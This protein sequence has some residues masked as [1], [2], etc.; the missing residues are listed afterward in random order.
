MSD[1]RENR[2]R[3]GALT[4]WL[5]ACTL[6]LAQAVGAPE[7][8]TTL[9]VVPRSPALATGSRTN[10]D[11]ELLR[12]ERAPDP[13]AAAERERRSSS[14][15]PS[16]VLHEEPPSRVECARVR[17][18]DSAS[19]MDLR[20]IEIATGAPA[21]L[22]VTGMPAPALRPMTLAGGV[23]SPIDADRLTDLVED[24]GSKVLL[25]RTPTHA[26]RAV[27]WD[28][29]ASEPGQVL[30]DPGATLTAHALGP[31][32]AEDLCLV[33]EQNAAAG[34]V[35]L[36]L[37]LPMGPDRTARFD[38]VPLG[39]YEVRV[40]TL[41]RPG[42][43]HARVDVEV[44]EASQHAFVE[45]N[46]TALEAPPEIRGTLH[47]PEAWGLTVPKIEVTA[48]CAL[49]R[50]FELAELHLTDG[51]WTWSVRGPAHGAYTV[52]VPEIGYA[53]PIRVRSDGPA[54]HELTVPEPAELTVVAAWL[55]R[56]ASVRW[57]SLEHDG[58]SGSVRVPAGF[59]G[60]NLRV[61]AGAIE[62]EIVDPHRNVLSTHRTAATPGALR[63]V[64]L[65]F[66]GE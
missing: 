10:E 40:R 34:P 44:S 16:S 29:S 15:S 23:A 49:P 41:R 35:R 22:T 20:H 18:V 48:V 58:F 13:E 38:G 6:L 21:S 24:C 36:Q 52:R 42:R 59:P 30:L 9:V 53:G 31:L 62:L 43:I 5:A 51:A 46:D 61:P 57:Q 12:P 11:A 50:P 25:F 55:S 27:R 7:T 33:L 19:G 54:V 47:L 39:N 60:V 17:V 45:L 56:P 63:D 4:V 65:N 3:I 28:P 2:R 64:V 32:P 37:E 66:E 26:W 8:P 1:R 14:G